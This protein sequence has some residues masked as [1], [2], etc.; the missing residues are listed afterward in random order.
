MDVQT[1]T[2]VLLARSL[3][4]LG[5]QKYFLIGQGSIKNHKDLK[6]S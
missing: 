3:A 5:F 6:V 2:L 1:A 4:E